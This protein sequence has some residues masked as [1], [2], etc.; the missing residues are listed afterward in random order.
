MAETVTD[1][2]IADEIREALR[3]D[4]RVRPE[5]IKLQV[6]GGVVTL[7]GTVGRHLDR[8]AAAEDAW[9]I[10]GVSEVRNL[11]QVEPDRLRD[12]EA[13]A[14][15]VAAALA[16]D[17]RV[18]DHSVVVN[19]AE[20][21]VRLSGTVRDEAERRAA[22]EDAWRVDGVVDVS[23][24]LTISADRRRPDDEI[25]QDVRAALDGDARIADPTRIHVSVVAATVTL[26]GTVA[27]VAERQAA[28]ND[29]WYT[30]GVVYVENLLSIARGQREQPAAA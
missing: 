13:V 4:G 22:E 2:K 9:R 23:N 26:A 30:A 1:Q 15:D 24:E 10:K 21:I 7:S 14:A 27:G 11:L 20:D 25:E 5:S 8:L 17:G 29:A 6:D 16:S 19:V 12:P 28:E 18:N 3:H